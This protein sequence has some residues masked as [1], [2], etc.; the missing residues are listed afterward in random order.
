MLN[1]PNAEKLV[2]EMMSELMKKR[3][4]RPSDDQTRM[5][6]LR[7][8]ALEVEKSNQELDIR[9]LRRENDE[10]RLENQEMQQKLADWKGAQIL[11]ELQH[12]EA[13]LP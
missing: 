1:D 8:D 9:I 13:Q 4:A 6:A 10:L 7:V 3:P 5:L 11:F 2:S 12:P